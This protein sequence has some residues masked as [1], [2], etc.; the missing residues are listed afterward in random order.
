MRHYLLGRTGLRVSELCLGTM[1]F[2]E[3]WGWGAPPE[4]CARIFEAYA[5]AGGTFIDTANNYTNGTSERI[6]GELIGPDRERFVLATKYSLAT[7]RGDPNAGG[8]HRKNMRQAV[9]ASLR[10]LRTDYVDILYL[11]MWDF[12]TSED[13]VMRG[14]DDLIR[15]G[16]ILHGAFSDTPD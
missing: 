3:E 14:F 6:L 10:R 12:T 9:D 1:T 15:A 2:G 13:E 5:A 11:H 4:E 16:K 8:N 7:R